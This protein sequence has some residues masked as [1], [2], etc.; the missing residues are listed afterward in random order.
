MGMSE[1]ER[2][3]VG[4]AMIWDYKMNMNES[5]RDLDRFIGETEIKA[6]TSLSRTTRWRLERAGNFPKKRKISPNRIAWLESEVLAWIEAKSN[7]DASEL[8]PREA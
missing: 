7:T 2:A 4:R 3:R 8:E 5:S 1:T 6:I